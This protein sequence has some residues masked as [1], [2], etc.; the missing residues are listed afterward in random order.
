MTIVI[1]G[2]QIVATHGTKVLCSPPLSVGSNLSPCWHEEADTRMMVHV[3]D[4]LGNGH[5]SIMIQTA[6]TDVVVLAVAVVGALS[7]EELWVSYGTGKSHKVLPA[8]VFAKALGSSKS[9]CLPFFHALTGCDTTS[10]FTGHGKKTAWTTWENFPDV[11]RAFL[12]LARAPSAISSG[13]LSLI[14]RYLILM[15]DK[16]SPL[17]KVRVDINEIVY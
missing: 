10:F 5:K 1:E 17:S 7:L 2:K 3:A 15:Y 12:E 8:H 9:R 6:D 4:A 16:T 11:T 13:S 14:E